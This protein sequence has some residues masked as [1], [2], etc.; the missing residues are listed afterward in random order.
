MTVLRLGWALTRGAGRRGRW[1]LL[2]MALGAALGAACLAAVLTLP[3]LLEARTVHEQHRTPYPAQAGA[4]ALDGA[5][6]RTVQGSWGTDALTEVLIAAPGRVVLPGGASAPRPGELLVSPRLRDLLAAEP[7]LRERLP[8]TVAGVLPGA[9]LAAPDE[10]YAYLGVQRGQLEQGQPLGGFGL[11]FRPPALLDGKTLHLLEFMLAVFVLLPLGLFLAGCNRLSAASRLRTLAALRLTGMSARDVRRLNALEPAGAAL[12]GAAAGLAGYALAARAGGRVGLPGLAWFPG[13][14]AP[15]AATVLLC[16]LGLPAGAVLISRAGTSALTDRPLEARRERPPRAPS[17]WRLLPLAAGLAAL[18]LLWLAPSR[19]GRPAGALSAPLL[20]AGVV[21]TGYGVV[22]CYPL[23]ARFLARRAARDPRSLSVLLGA[24]RGELEPGGAVRATAGL[25]LFVFAL[26]LAHGVFRDWHAAAQPRRPVQYVGV[27]GAEAPGLD[28]ARLRALPGV[29][30]AVLTVR[31]LVPPPS[32]VPGHRPVTATALLGTCADLARFT[33]A[34]PLGCTDGVPLLLDTGNGVPLP[35][36]GTELRFPTGPG[37]GSDGG[38]DGG[39]DRSPG[40]GSDG[41]ADGGADAV[42]VRVPSGRASVSWPAD[43]PLYGTGLLLPPGTLPDG[44]AAT[45]TLTLAARASTA[46]VQRV[47]GGLAA[48][49]PAAEPVLYG[50]DTDGLRKARLVDSLYTAGTA[51]GVAVTVLAHLVAALDRA[52]ERRRN[53]TALTLIGVPRRT[54]RRAQVVQTVLFLGCGLLPAVAAGALAGRAYDAYGGLVHAWD[55]P[56]FARTLAACAAVLAVAV[57]GA[58][59]L[60]V[61]RID[62]ALIRR[63]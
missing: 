26:G 1:R 52:L 23:A 55:W 35:E 48:A 3:Q 12:L 36:P 22:A 47:L 31:N 2:L 4:P 15:S 10:L 32:T 17:R 9:L 5:S 13:D 39:S 14:A 20:L 51:L 53:V 44:A 33:A 60:L 29:D 56:A 7:A 18:G 30:G 40:N 8:G 42:T 59:P 37:G 62:P 24:R 34:P 57:L 58:L 19:S 43:S 27:A 63:D 28:P 25:V 38:T 61:R 41:G 45:G 50:V 54:L 11:A 49:A 21:A 16:L 6:F 46:T